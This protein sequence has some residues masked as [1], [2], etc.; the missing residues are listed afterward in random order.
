MSIRNMLAI[1]WVPIASVILMAQAPTDPE[2]T[3]KYPLT[4]REGPWLIHV[5]SFRGDQSL[6]FAQRLADEVRTKHR[7][8]S[9]VYSMNEKDAKDDREQLRQYQMKMI[10]SDKVAESNE[11]QKFK[12]VRIIKE[13]S[14]FVGNYPDMEKAR[15]QAEVIKAF[16]PPASIPSYVVNLFNES[17]AVEKADPKSSEIAGLFKL[18]TGSRTEDRKLL[19]A[20]QGNPFR[21]AFVVRNPFFAKSKVPTVVK[22]Q[23]AAQMDDPPI[24]TAWA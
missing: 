23:T 18:R 10:G 22:Q 12:T 8:L 17:N 2:P 21:Q 24:G 14:V 16:P 13:Y 5:A 19:A 6:E 7:L 15:E 4:N 3:I 20:K 1:V 9:F 11:P